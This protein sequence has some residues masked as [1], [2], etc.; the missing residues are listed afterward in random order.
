MNFSDDPHIDVCQD[1]ETGLKAEY[2]RHPSLTDTMCIF[3]LES[4]KIASKQAFGFGKNEK[5]ARSPLTGGIVDWCVHVATQR[6]DKVNALTLKE[7]NQCP[8]RQDHPVGPS[9]LERRSSCLLRVHQKL[10]VRVKFP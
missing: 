7:F 2:E 3:A 4:A 9:T 5:V 8:A 6:V 10:C 1:I